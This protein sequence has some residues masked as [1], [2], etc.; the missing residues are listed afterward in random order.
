LSQYSCAKKSSNIKCKYKK[1]RAKLS[2]EKGVRKM[3]AKFNI[4]VEIQNTF[5]RQVLKIFVTLTLILEPIK[6]KK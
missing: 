2:N 6:H 5:F 1:L 3:L 4:L